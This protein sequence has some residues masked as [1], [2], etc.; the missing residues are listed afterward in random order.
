MAARLQTLAEPGQVVI[1]ESTLVAAQATGI[2]LV[3]APL[4]DLEVKGRVQTVRAYTVS[5]HE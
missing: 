1:G 5:G 3:T 4:G 2:K